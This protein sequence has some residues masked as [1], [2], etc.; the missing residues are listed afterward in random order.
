MRTLIVASVLVV[1]LVVAA[2]RGASPRDVHACTGGFGG[3]L[4]VLAEYPNIAL[5]EAVVVGDGV[6]RAP[7]LTPTAPAEA[8]ATLSPSEPRTPVSPPYATPSGPLVPPTASVPFDVS[9]YG[10]TLRVIESYA[11]SARGD[12]RDRHGDS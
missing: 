2:A 3:P 12:V 10:A 9:G 5:V 11:G 4:E 1:V 8:T 6:N 7:T